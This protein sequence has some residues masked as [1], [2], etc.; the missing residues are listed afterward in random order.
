MVT[1]VTFNS[2]LQDSNLND[3]GKCVLSLKPQALKNSNR[4]INL[5]P[6]LEPLRSVIMSQHTALEPHI[7]ELGK[8]CLDF[9]TNIEKKKESS[10]KLITENRTP[11][12]LRLKCELTT[13]PSYE[14]NRD[15]IIL[16]RELNEAVEDF[17][18]K[19][20]NIMKRWSHINIRLLKE[21]RCFNVLK[22]ATN[23]MDALFTYWTDVFLPLS[24]PNQVTNNLILFL[25]KIYF[26]TDYIDDIDQIRNYFDL[27]TSEILLSISKILTKNNGDKYN[28]ELVDSMDLTFLDNLE[29]N[30][31][32]IVNETLTTFDTIL[33][34]TMIL[35]WDT[36]QKKIRLAEAAQKLN[37]KLEAE[38]NT[39]ATVATSLAINKARA[40]MAQNNTTNDATQLRIAILE[41]QLLQQSQTSKEILNQLKNRKRSDRSQLN[42]P[43]VPDN[44]HIFPPESVI[45]LT[46]KSPEKFNTL[47]QIQKNKKPRLQWDTNISQTLQFPSW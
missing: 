8:I 2:H 41:K 1:P 34:A 20:L 45:D 18:L 3:I 26:E 9:T 38:R 13:S 29:E 19:G 22:K 46:L 39:S 30:N 14:N 31:L 15:F 27:P 43:S 11:R 16:K 36:N 23:I 33:C 17:T 40:N 47:S 37:A 21:D 32:I 12:S 6:D 28:L 44:Q 7:K 25:S 10:H 5:T 4:N 35:L 24:W 42:Q